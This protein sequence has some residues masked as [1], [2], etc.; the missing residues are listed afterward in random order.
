[1]K[2]KILILLS[3]LILYPLITG[4][5]SEES[6][7]VIVGNVETPVYNVEVSWD[8]MQFVY[9]EQ[10]NYEWNNISHTYELGES[11]YRWS[12]TNNNIKV[13]NNSAFPINISLNY[14][15]IKDN[16]DGNFNVSNT[17]INQGNTMNF[18]LILDGKLSNEAVNYTS[19]GTVNLLIS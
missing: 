5:I 14:I 17:I 18:Q 4:Y 16:I 19:I 13:E 8:S 10:I 1:M 12:A 7:S 11:T 15:S 2:N 3:F 9:N 6:Q